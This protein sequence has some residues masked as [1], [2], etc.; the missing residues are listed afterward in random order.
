MCA[1]FGNAGLVSFPAEAP[2]V[3]ARTLGG[4][5]GK[6]RPRNRA[7]VSERSRG[8]RYRTRPVAACWALSAV[9][10]VACSGSTVDV[11]G[12]ALPTGLRSYLLSPLDGWAP[13][14]LGPRSGKIVS[15]K[16]ER[17]DLGRSED[18]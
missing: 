10:F 12:P 1:N 18:S 2:S 4:S 11:G 6:L 13:P 14:P 3:P 17:N 15:R 7:P 9:V 5:G 16:A 8:R